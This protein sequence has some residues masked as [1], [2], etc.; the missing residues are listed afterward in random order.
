M[1][2]LKNHGLLKLKNRLKVFDGCYLV[3]NGKVTV[4]VEFENDLK[5]V[6]LQT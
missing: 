5:Y 4:N 6:T 1:T 3:C 2:I